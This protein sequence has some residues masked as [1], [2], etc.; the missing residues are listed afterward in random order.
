[1]KDHVS[2]FAR[3]KT[4]GWQGYRPLQEEYDDL[5]QEKSEQKGK[6]F[7]EMHRVIM[8]LKSWLRGM[9]HHVNDLQD[10]LNEYCYRFNRFNLKKGIFDNL[11][12]RMVQAPPCYI[13]SLSD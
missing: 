4:D 5:A 13:F 9:H 8:L 12:N 3:I 7:P 6:N 11:M 2:R 1:M 10:Y